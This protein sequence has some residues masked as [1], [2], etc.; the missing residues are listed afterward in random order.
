MPVE[1]CLQIREVGKPEIYNRV[2]VDPCGSFDRPS[3]IRDII[4]RFGYETYDLLIKEQAQCTLDKALRKVKQA[5]YK[6]ID[7]DII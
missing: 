6:V 4:Q 1:I 7:G 5:G 3:V 2:I